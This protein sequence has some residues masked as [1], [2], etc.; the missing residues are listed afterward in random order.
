[1]SY[2]EA[3]LIR[4]PPG[5]LPDGVRGGDGRRVDGAVVGHHEP[6]AA[7]VELEPGLITQSHKS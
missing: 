3:D 6:P 7:V 4:R 2:L 5:V 1:M